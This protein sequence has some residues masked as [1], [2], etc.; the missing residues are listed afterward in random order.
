[1][2][3]TRVRSR[4]LVAWDGTRQRL[5]E[6]G[7]LVHDDDMIV[8]VGQEFLG[9]VDV[10]VDAGDAL[11]LPGLV[12]LHVHGGS[13]AVGRLFADAVRR[14]PRMLGFLHYA[15]PREEGAAGAFAPGDTVS[16]AR[17][18]LLECL[19]HGCTTVVEIG[20]ETGVNPDQMAEAARSLGVRVHAGI[21]FRSYDYV[22]HA[23]GKI[24]Y[25]ERPDRG[26][27]SF[28]HAIA[29]AEAAL[30][31]N[32]PWVRPMLFPL[33]LDTCT[34]ELLRDARQESDRLGI[35]I[36]LHAA[37]GWFEYTQIM[38][39]TGLAPVPWL[40]RLGMLGPRTVL[41]HAVYV[42]GHSAV[43]FARDDDIA[44]LADAGTGV[45]HC[46]TVLA[47]RGI[48]LE[49]FERYRRAGVPVAIGTDTFPRDPV[50]EGRL[51]A[52]LSRVLDRDP[53]SASPWTILSALSDVP[54]D[55]LGR[56]DLGRL[57]PG[58]SA[59]YTTVGLGRLRHGPVFDPVS[60]WLHCATGDDVQ[61]VVVGGRERLSRADPTA[62]ERESTLREHQQHEA[63]T[64]WR[65]VPSWYVQ[66]H[67]LDHIAAE[68]HDRKW[69]PAAA[70]ERRRGDTM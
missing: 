1:M 9:L 24:G 22:T 4:W 52:Y 29:W 33:Q 59:D 61:R 69:Q 70:H 66:A 14:E 13:F 31:R 60:T 44:L 49:S 62:L 26:A 65:E 25:R 41:A 17:A 21:G 42:A 45:A 39:R 16:A 46:P 5:I 10:E 23:D 36:Q 63:A 56:S 27:S 2:S 20:G 57:A 19:R 43:P 28:R 3:V 54:A 51:A 34:P 6:N 53:G 55:L 15:A 40:D 7:E 11:I 64:I 35:S 30:E 18:T 48:A 8:F 12:N 50:Q 47:R 32:D 67:E 37:Q 68:T 58:C 38:D